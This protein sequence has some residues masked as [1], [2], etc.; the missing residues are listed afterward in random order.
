MGYSRE[1]WATIKP[2][3]FCVILALIIV[4]LIFSLEKMRKFRKEEFHKMYVSSCRVIAGAIKSRL[5][6]RAG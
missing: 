2:Y 3:N 5:L 1:S 4:E 6:R